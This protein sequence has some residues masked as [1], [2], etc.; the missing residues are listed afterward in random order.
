MKFEIS[1]IAGITLN[2]LTGGLGTLLF[3]VLIGD[4]YTPDDIDVEKCCGWCWCW[5]CCI[6]RCCAYIW[7]SAQ[8]QKAIYTLIILIGGFIGY[9]GFKFQTVADLEVDVDNKKSVEY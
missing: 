5:Y 8:C 1:G 2:I 7:S 3:I 9:F 4:S 6:Y